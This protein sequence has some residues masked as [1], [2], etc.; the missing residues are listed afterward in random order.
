MTDF[1]PHIVK[2]RNLLSA[3]LSKNPP[4][5]SSRHLRVVQQLKYW[6]TQLPPLH[7]PGHTSPRILQTDASN[8]Y[9]GAV[10]LIVEDGKRHV[11]GY[12]SGPFTTAESHYHSTFKEILAVK[13][14]IEKFQFHLIG[15][16]F[17]VEMDSSTFP[18]MLISN[19]RPSPTPNFSDGLLG[20]QT[21]L[22]LSNT[23]R[24]KIMN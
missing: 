19:K 24:E 17:T 6:S 7:I 21:G 8:D 13:R 4:P 16:H 18:Q 9:W 3:L 20:S 14:G 15:H 12:K 1:I 11:C 2:P 23:S 22:S 5:W 10:L